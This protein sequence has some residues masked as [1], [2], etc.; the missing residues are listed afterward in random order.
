[1][2]NQNLTICILEDDP[3]V[4]MLLSESISSLGCQVQV[5]SSV[6]EFNQ[7]N[8]ASMADVCI[9]D[10]QLPDGNGIDVCREIRGQGYDKTKIIFSSANED[11][12]TRLMAYEAGADD[13]M[14]KP[15]PPEEIA[16]KVS[17]CI[18]KIQADRSIENQVKYASDTAMTAITTLGEMGIV[19]EFMRE[20][21]ACDQEHAISNV[22]ANASKKYDLSAI[23]EVKGLLGTYYAGT[24]GDVSELARTLLQRSRDMGKIVQ[25]NGRLLVNSPRIAILVTALSMEDLDKVGRIRDHLALIVDAAEIRLKSLE[26]KIK[27]QQQHRIMQEAVSGLIEIVDS[28]YKDQENKQGAIK[29]AA[30]D[31]TNDLYNTFV[32]L[33]LTDQQEGLL[34]QRAQAATKRLL[35]IQD[36][37]SSVNQQLQPI[38]HQLQEIVR[39]Q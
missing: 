21:F 37:S 10:I 15:C 9:I 38:I 39:E 30:I 31:Y 23:I 3:I 20:M 8:R 33:M 18:E 1:M 6:D 2:T 35:E 26:D 19:I 16:H 17:L 25:M 32:H 12:D 29:Q 14:V 24:E 27:I 28:I 7:Q 36:K 4:S 13:Y 22:I 11:I 34:L 5:A